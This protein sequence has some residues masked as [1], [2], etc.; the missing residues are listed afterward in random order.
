LEEE[1]GNYK[2]FIMRKKKK[3]IKIS[4]IIISRNEEEKLADCL[5]SL[6]WVDELVVIDNASTDKTPDIAKKEGARVIRAP[7]EY[8][9]RY[10]ELRNLGLKNTTGEWVLYVDSDERVT[11][12][13]KRE[14]T[15][16]LKRPVTKYSAYAIPRR[17]FIFGF[18]L[19]HVGLW[20]DYVIR[21]F[22][23]KK[24][25]KWVKD[26]HEEPVFEGEIKHMENPLIHVK[27]KDLSEMVDKTNGWSE[28]EAKLMYD[29]GHPQM[30]IP[31]FLTAMLREFWLRMVRQTAFIDGS[32][33]IIYA[34]YLVYSKFIS[35]A[36]LWE[37][38]V[39]NRNS[40]YTKH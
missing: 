38:Q 33:G 3:D 11:P 8:A 36:K 5:R 4:A 12:S 1:V 17:N 32:V 23:R 40:T 39:A 15:L 29:A 31:R 18:E 37:L 14:I 13:L 7:E 30:N 16:L 24:L 26:L 25:K 19:K 9:L 35:Y 21:L 2:A 28:I 27:H 10:S 20:P 22:L 34:I 6:K